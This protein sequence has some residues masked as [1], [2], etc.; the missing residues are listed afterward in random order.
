MG[1]RARQR[2]I[3]IAIGCLISAVLCIVI[4]VAIGFSLKRFA[5]ELN[6]FNR[7]QMK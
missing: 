3:G 6:N 2:L 4:L 5:H 1:E 7:P